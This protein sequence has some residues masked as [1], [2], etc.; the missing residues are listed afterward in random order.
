MASLGLRLAVALPLFVV[1]HA[2]VGATARYVIEPLLMV[3]LVNLAWA[4]G[5][6]CT[7]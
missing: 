5:R 7:V 3:A 6:V 2:A 4:V 1:I